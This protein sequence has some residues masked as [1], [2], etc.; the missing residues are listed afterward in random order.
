M[1]YSQA[2]LMYTPLSTMEDGADKWKQ[3]SRRRSSWRDL[4]MSLPIEQ[5]L[6]GEMAAKQLS[7]PRDKWGVIEMR[8]FICSIRKLYHVPTVVSAHF[9][10]SSWDHRV[11]LNAKHPSSRTQMHGQEWCVIPSM[12]FRFKPVASPS[13]RPEV[14]QCMAPVL[15]EFHVFRQDSRTIHCN[16]FLEIPAT[17]LAAKPQLDATAEAH[18]RRISTTKLP[19]PSEV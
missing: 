16:C 17:C 6:K 18:F 3:C 14:I 8:G 7:K 11:L 1:E 12:K 10:W 2:G 5:G 19:S 4:N 13:F 15:G 9:V